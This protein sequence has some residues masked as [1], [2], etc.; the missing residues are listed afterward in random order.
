MSDTQPGEVF[1]NLSTAEWM[2]AAGSA[3]ILVVVYLIGNRIQ[4]EY[5]AS[6][7]LIA[8][9]LSLAV[10]LAVFVRNAGNESAWNKLYPGTV[11]LAGVVI[12]AFVAMDLLNGLAN[13]F[14]ESGEFYEITLYIAAAVM[15]VG[16]FQLRQEG[17]SG[18]VTSF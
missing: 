12:V 11:N 15:A 10:L 2:I 8:A 17:T 4:Y 9:P 7:Q 5:F 14:S 18:E 6:V 13:D 1:N 3:W 16:L